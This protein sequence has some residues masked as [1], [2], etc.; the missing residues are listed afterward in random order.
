MQLTLDY[1]S[2]RRYH[3]LNFNLSAIR[4]HHR[5][6]GRSMNSWWNSIEAVLLFNSWMEIVS[7]GGAALTLIS[8]VL[9]WRHGNRMA[10]EL[11]GRERRASK[12]IK[13][14]ESAAEEIRKE[15]LT[16]QQSQDIADQQRR[17]ALMDAESLR[18]EMQTLRKRYSDAEGS[19][20]SRIEALKDIGSTQGITQSSTMSQGLSE[21]TTQIDDQQKKMLIKLLKTGPKG[22]LDIISV[23][24]DPASLQAAI[25]LKS[26]FDDHGWT[27]QD[28]V[29]SAFAQNPEGIALVIH[30]KQTAPSYAKFVQRTL[31]SA[32]LPVSAQINNKYREW[33][34][35]MIVGQFDAA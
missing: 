21:R 10:S 34:L 9:L 29:Q 27:T 11:I 19:L 5:V 22:E 1:P 33:S 7:L 28:I 8:L 23:L 4:N 17:L 26:I 16:T 24:D 6:R 25:E 12:R 35:S 15:L 31:T 2:I 30:S 13:A 20:K 14:V 3:S 18:N 32:G